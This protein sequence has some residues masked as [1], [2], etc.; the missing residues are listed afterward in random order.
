MKKI[1]LILVALLLFTGCSVVR[2]DTS[3]IDNILNVIL[4]KDNKLFNQVGQG[5]K[6]Y[7]PSDVT[8]IESDGLND[9]LYSNGT[10]YYLYV[11]AIS[12]YYKTSNNYSENKEAYYS[13]VFNTKDGF[14]KSGYLDI[15]E[16]KNMYY[17]T[18]VYNY[19]KIEAVV[20]E[21]NLNNAVLN[22]SYI[23]S[24]IKYNEDIVELMLEED[25]FTNKTGKLKEY[26]NTSTSEKFVLE[27]ENELKEG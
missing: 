10:Y 5:Y 2:I 7:L 24:T 3:S 23:L 13:K 9:V 12:Y 18:F 21:E 6:Y 27:K 25:Y 14:K 17:L 19:A 8:Y 26:D 22:A 1:I 16:E 11:D 15:V 4:T 20:N